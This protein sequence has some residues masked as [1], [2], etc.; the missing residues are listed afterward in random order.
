MVLTTRPK[1]HN[2]M[3]LVIALCL[4]TTVTAYAPVDPAYLDCDGDCSQTAS[5]L[6]PGPLIAACGPAWKMGT[7]LWVDG[8]G[9]VMCGDRFGRPPAPHAVDVWF[10]SRE[11]AL[12]W[13]WR[14]RHPVCQLDKRGGLGVYLPIP[15]QEPPM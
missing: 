7:W 13:G 5:G 12:R 11:L 9:T 2:L 1:R 14:T 3:N 8:Y 4:A 15:A 6:P 10:P